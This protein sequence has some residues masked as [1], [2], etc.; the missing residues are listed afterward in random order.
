VAGERL[1]ISIHDNKLEILA[2]QTNPEP[3]NSTPTNQLLDVAPSST[4]VAEPEPVTASTNHSDMPERVHPTASAIPQ[5]GS[6]SEPDWRSLASSGKYK[7][8]LAAAES[9]GFFQET[10]RANASELLALAD[11]ARFAGSPARAR[12]ALLAA[13]TRFGVRGRTAFLI[14][15]IAADQ[16]RSAGEAASWFETYLREEPGGP[17]AEQAL[18]RLLEIRRRG[19]ANA[20]RTL[21][22]RYLAK[23]PRGAYAAL[24]R[25]VLEP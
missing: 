20:A 5:A 25:S 18:G 3:T 15:K 16:Q 1:R 17:L 24:A 4:A 12:E 23:Y 9:A 21:A 8:A 13:R 11:A 2:N 19:D 22:E 10:A 7:D 14:G 6:S